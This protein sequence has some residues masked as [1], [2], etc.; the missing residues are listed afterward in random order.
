MNSYTSISTY[1]CVNIMRVFLH[2]LQLKLELFEAT[3][4]GLRDCCFEHDICYG[5]CS[6]TKKECDDVLSDCM[7]LYCHSMDTERHRKSCNVASNLMDTSVEKLG[8]ESY[9]KLQEEA[10]DCLAEKHE[11][12]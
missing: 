6:K 11:E 5:T 4:P 12:L 8:C 2:Q 7:D 9:L 3:Y 1:L 10:C